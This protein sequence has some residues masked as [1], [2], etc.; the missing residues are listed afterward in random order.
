MTIRPMLDLAR[1]L[2][3]RHG[4]WLDIGECELSAG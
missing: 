1:E 2:S 3:G 4:K